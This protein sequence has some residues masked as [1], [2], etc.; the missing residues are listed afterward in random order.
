MIRKLLCLSVIAASLSI[1]SCQKEQVSEQTETV[2]VQ[3]TN[4]VS[5]QIRKKVSNLNF[6]SKHVE[7]NN[8][9]LPDGSFI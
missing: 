7:K 2:S 5:D 1:T 6:N 3:E 4:E 8:M 9:L